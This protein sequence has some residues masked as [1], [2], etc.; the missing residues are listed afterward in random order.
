MS[1][2]SQDTEPYLAILQCTFVH[3]LQTKQACMFLSLCMRL[4][5]LRV[6]VIN[7]TQKRAECACSKNYFLAMTGP[8]VG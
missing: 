2:G 6:H 4:R 8:R 3:N 5:K 1:V 7:S